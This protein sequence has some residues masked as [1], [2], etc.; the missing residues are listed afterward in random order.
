VLVV[1]NEMCRPFL[2]PSDPTT[3]TTLEA[4]CNTFLAVLTAYDQAGRVDEALNFSEIM[5]ELAEQTGDVFLR[6]NRACYFALIWAQAKV[7]D[8]DSD[9][10]TLLCMQEVFERGRSIGHGYAKQ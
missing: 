1:Q 3:A 9:L 7:G 4:T 6:P 2:E 5:E 8:T 10:P